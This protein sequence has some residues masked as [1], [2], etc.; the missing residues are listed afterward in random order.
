MDSQGD[1]DDE[2]DEDDFDGI[3]DVSPSQ[4][5]LPSVK[6]SAM[7]MKEKGSTL[8]DLFSDDEDSGSEPLATK[9]MRKEGNQRSQSKSPNLF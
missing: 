2:E 6:R 7:K 1:E 8:A 5:V 3:E 9:S 4:I